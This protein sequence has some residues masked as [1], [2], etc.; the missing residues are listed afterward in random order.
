MLEVNDLGTDISSDWII[1]NGD[2]IL[3]HNEDNIAQSI[4]NRL[5]CL[6]GGLDTYYLE[7]G[8]FL[9]NFLG[10]RQSKETLEFI[11]IEIERSL[12]QDPRLSDFSVEVSYNSVG[13]INININIY[14][15]ETTDF[16]LNLVIGENNIVTLTDIIDNVEYEEED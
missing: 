7:Y 1:E 14:I 3:V 15:D 5:Q 13:E 6:K 12:Q 9:Y 2:L 10:F 11:R 8:S 4:L 16:S